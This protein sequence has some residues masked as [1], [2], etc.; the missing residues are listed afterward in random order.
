[1]WPPR[2]TNGVLTRY[3]AQFPIDCCGIIKCKARLAY[4][5]GVAGC[6]LSIPSAVEGPAKSFA[7]QTGLWLVRSEFCTFDT[8]LSTVNSQPGQCSWSVHADSLE[9]QTHHERPPRRIT[10]LECTL[11]NNGFVDSLECLVTNSLDLKPPG[12][13]A[14]WP[15]GGPEVLWRSSTPVMG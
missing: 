5:N 4:P 2:S 9:M 6:G 14:S 15:C 11:T 8:E 3:P 12:I 10:L 13:R 1:M 7:N